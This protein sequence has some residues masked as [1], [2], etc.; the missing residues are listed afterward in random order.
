MSEKV[1]RIIK[2]SRCMEVGD[3]PHSEWSLLADDPSLPNFLA[4]A[5]N[6][7]DA[8]VRSVSKRSPRDRLP[9]VRG[10]QSKSAR[11]R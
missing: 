2:N 9:R 5:P 7:L 6:F 1:S 8:S 3:L 11:D 10:D 4:N